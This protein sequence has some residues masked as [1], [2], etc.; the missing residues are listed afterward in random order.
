MAKNGSPIDLASWRLVWGWA[1]IV[2]LAMA[3]TRLLADPLPDAKL[4]RL[5][6]GRWLEFAEYGD[7]RGP[8]I[9]Y[10]HGVP[11]SHVEVLAANAE[12]QDARVHLIAL[13][14]PG[15]GNSTFLRG[16]QVLDWPKDVCEF[17]AITG[18]D[19]TSFGIMAF[20][21][22]TPYALACARIIPNRITRIAIVSGH[23]SL[24]IPGVVPGAEDKT[25]ATLI[26]RPAL[27]E[28]GVELTRHRL[29]VKPDKL[30]A[31]VTRRWD[32][33]DLRLLE[34]DTLVRGLLEG[35]LK[36]A[37]VA[38]GQGVVL[39]AQLLGRYWGFEL[40]EVGGPPISIWHGAGDRIAPISMAHYLQEHLRNS[41][42]RVD[43]T[44]GHVTT[45]KWHCGEIVSEF[46]TD[47][48][49]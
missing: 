23:T 1:A 44:A 22:G 37:T 16:R 36:Q 14:R 35:S 34:N 25:I 39:D 42:L 4:V 12:I 11:G 17:L 31:R 8:L 18:R 19:R 33:N 7:P 47:R 24:G 48:G 26:R 38:G 30:M 5:S 27:A 9:L 40:S 41:T 45:F 13:N 10:F 3:P 28:K 32:S 21:G 43:P 2:L 29:Q 46:V 6:D 20:S 15:I 49:E